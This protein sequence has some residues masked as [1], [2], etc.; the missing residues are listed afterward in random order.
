M[1]DNTNTKSNN[2]KNIIKTITKNSANVDE[3]ARKDIEKSFN[4]ENIHGAEAYYSN[5]YGWTL[6]KIIS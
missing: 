1:I 4:I 5:R 6:R 3:L 2:Y